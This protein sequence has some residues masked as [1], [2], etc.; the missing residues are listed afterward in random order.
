MLVLLFQDKSVKCTRAVAMAPEVR[1]GNLLTR[2]QNWPVFKRT[3]TRLSV[4]RLTLYRLTLSTTVSCLLLT[5]MKGT[6]KTEPK[7]ISGKYLF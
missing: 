5:L 2:S 6:E 3:L 1:V 7:T 4:N